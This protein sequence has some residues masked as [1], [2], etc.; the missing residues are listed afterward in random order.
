MKLI[1]KRL[2]RATVIIEKINSNLVV[3]KI[4]E[5]HRN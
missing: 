1:I 2:I 4:G 3:E 5:V